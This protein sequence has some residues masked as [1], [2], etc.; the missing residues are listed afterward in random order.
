MTC[1][2]LDRHFVRLKNI[3]NEYIHGVL[4]GRNEFSNLSEAKLGNLEGLNQ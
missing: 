3:V 2:D 1:Q 4:N